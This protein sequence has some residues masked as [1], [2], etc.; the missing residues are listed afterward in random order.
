MAITVV[1]FIYFGFI[2]YYRNQEGRFTLGCILAIF[3]FLDFFLFTC[4]TSS[5]QS[6]EIM[7]FFSLMFAFQAIQYNLFNNFTNTKERSTFPNNFRSSMNKVYTFF[8]LLGIF[9]N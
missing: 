9:V 7:L 2:H 3:G 5:I 6:R 1:Y 8:Y 4:G